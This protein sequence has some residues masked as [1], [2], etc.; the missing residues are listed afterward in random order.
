[1]VYLNSVLKVIDNSGARTVKCIKIY[2][3]SPKSCAVVGDLLLVVVKTYTPN[4]KV[5]KGELY[6]AVVVRSA[7]QASRYG[8]VY[9]RCG[10]S[11]VVLLNQRMM[12]L[13]SRVLSAVCIELCKIPMFF[14]IVSMA[15]TII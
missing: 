13:G 6:K 8:G 10:E 4:K 12:P 3:K 11:A 9:I 7:K 14:R 15:P 1:M 2:N 5:K